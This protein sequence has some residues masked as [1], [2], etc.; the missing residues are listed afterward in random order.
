MSGNAVLQHG[1]PLLYRVQKVQIVG[2]DVYKVARL[3]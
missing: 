1:F 3:L 2:S